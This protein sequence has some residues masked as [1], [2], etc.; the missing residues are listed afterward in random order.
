MS[1]KEEIHAQI[2]G[3]LAGANF[4]IKTP[5]DLLAAFPQGAD[6]ICQVAILR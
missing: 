1:V 4:P 3:A 5:K 6:T 2:T